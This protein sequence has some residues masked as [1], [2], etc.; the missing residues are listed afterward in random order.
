MPLPEDLFL[1]KSSEKTIFTNNL[2]NISDAPSPAISAIIV[3]IAKYSSIFNVHQARK[4]EKKR[5]K[6]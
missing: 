3:E 1:S 6:I 4:K 5:K 2:I